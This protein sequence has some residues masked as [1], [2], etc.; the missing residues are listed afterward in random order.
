MGS[1][2]NGLG[3]TVPCLA[4][5]RWVV[6]TAVGVI[7][8]AVVV[9]VIRMVRRREEIQIT[10]DRGR[11]DVDGIRSNASAEISAFITMGN[12]SFRGNNPIVCTKMTVGLVDVQWSS[13]FQLPADMAGQLAEAMN[14]SIV[15]LNSDG[16]ITLPKESW[17][18]EVMV[19]SIDDGQ[20][21]YVAS[22]S[23][24]DGDFE[25]L[26]LLQV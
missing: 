11:I 14:Q 26:V 19:E 25:V 4:A 12:P 18:T 13:A 20:W 6:A 2:D 15:I 7:A 17:H 22:R 23:R 3:K 5:V 21:D 8:F 16:N 1:D 9:M 24:K 10:I